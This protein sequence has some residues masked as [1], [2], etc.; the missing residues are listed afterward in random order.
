MGLRR[1]SADLFQFRYFLHEQASA[2]DWAC[3]EGAARLAPLCYTECASA[4]LQGFNELTTLD[5][6]A[7]AAKIPS[8]MHLYFLKADMEVRGHQAGSHS[9]H[10]WHI[11]MLNS[12]LHG[13]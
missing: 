12:E 1:I 5:L 4:C 11:P 9:F 2:S 8:D 13:T 10:G 7:E 6:A 3:K